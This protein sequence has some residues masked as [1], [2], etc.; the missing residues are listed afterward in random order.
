VQEEDLSGGVF[1]DE[2]VQEGQ[3]DGMAAEHVIAACSNLKQGTNC[4]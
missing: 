1:S 4:R 2:E 3:G